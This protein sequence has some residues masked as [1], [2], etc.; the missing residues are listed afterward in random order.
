G[1]VGFSIPEFFLALALMNVAVALFIFFQVPEFT[2]RFLVWLL[3]HGMYRVRHH[4]LEAIPA[5]GG[6]VLVCN[7]VSYVDA[8]LIGGAIHRPVRF[9]MDRDIYRI[10]VLNYLFRAGGAIPICPR[11]ENEEAY[12]QAMDQIAARLEDGEL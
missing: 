3:G 1:L 9:V 8:M 10:P 6:A 4:G 2:L 12:Q 7:H 11:K 5:K